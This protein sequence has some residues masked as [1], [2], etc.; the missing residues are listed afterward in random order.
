MYR[1][2]RTLA[3]GLALGLGF[4]PGVAAVQSGPDSLQRAALGPLRI[5]RHAGSDAVVFLSGRVSSGTDRLTLASAPAETALAFLDR[6]EDALGM[7]HAVAVLRPVAG[8]VTVDELGMTHVRLEQHENGVRVFGA[9]VRVHYSADGESVTALNGDFVTG[10]HVSTVANIGPRRA[11]RIARSIEPD[12]VLWRE[13]E[14]VV[15]TNRIDPSV[16]GNHLAWL[17]MLVDETV[18]SRRLYVIDAHSTAVIKTRDELCSARNRR[19]YDLQGA[20][21]GPGVLVRSEGEGPTG[22]ADVNAAYDYT[23]DAYD[24]FASL[25]GRDSFDDNCAAIVSRVHFGVEVFNAFWTGTDLIFGDGMTVDDIVAHE[26]SHAIIQHTADLIYQ[27]QSGAMNEAYADIFGEAVD[28]I[29]GSGTD[30]PATKWLLGEDS[31]RGAFRDMADPPRLGQPDKATLWKCTTADSGGVHTNSGVFNKAAVL[32]ADGGT[33]NG[34]TVQGIG[35][36]KMVRVHYRALTVYLTPAST[37]L[38]NYLSLNQACLDLEGANGFT[39]ADCAEV[40]RALL[41]VEMD[42]IVFCNVTCPIQNAVSVAPGGPVERARLLLA[43]YRLRERLRG[44]PNGRRLVELYY[45]HAGEASTLLA[46]DEELGRLLAVLLARL[47]PVIEGATGDAVGE[48][49]EGTQRLSAHTVA[50]TA[51]LLR[52]FE[53]AAPNSDLARAIGNE[54]DAL[55]LDRLVGRTLMEALNQ[56]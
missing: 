44:T 14:L 35:V 55:G 19:V 51:A 18:P 22:D 6:H 33:F 43:A 5:D 46:G 7:R 38:A 48:G 8:S 40:N 36:E 31:P 42:T 2:V 27:D 20:T 4:A 25:F 9:E 11:V 49:A 37:L 29:N 15:Y 30:T 50:L 24:Y 16:S 52:R 3:L 12:G 34:F 41:A 23:G 26:Y 17:V 53:E 13:P 21:E 10:V 39:I 47:T 54:R 32:M 56:P 1:T 28:L 45:E